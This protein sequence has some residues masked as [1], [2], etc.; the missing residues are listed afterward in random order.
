MAVEGFDA[1]LPIETAGFVPQVGLSEAPDAAGPTLDAALAQA[2]RPGGGGNPAG[3]NGID[4]DARR[5]A[6][7]PDL[8]VEDPAGPYRPPAQVAHVNPLAEMFAGNAPADDPLILHKL[9]IDDMTRASAGRYGDSTEDY[10]WWE[11]TTGDFEWAKRCFMMDVYA[12]VNNAIRGATSQAQADQLARD[13]LHLVGLESVVHVNNPEGEEIVV[14]ARIFNLL[15]ANIDCPLLTLDPAAF[16]NLQL[17]SVGPDLDRGNFEIHVDPDVQ[18]TEDN[19]TAL[20]RLMHIIELVQTYLAS[21]PDNGV[22]MTPKGPITVAELRANYAMTDFRITA[23]GTSYAA[24]GI[25]GYPGAGSATYNNGNP[26]FETSIDHLRDFMITEMRALHFILHEL[27]HV[28]SV[29]YQDFL[30]L[31]LYG[32]PSATDFVASEVFANDISHTIAQA[33]AIPIIR[34]ST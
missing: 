1:A 7:A 20:S 22:F 30:N 14:T 16:A 21:L 23:E 13:Y 19:V 33:R 4:H 5:E 9:T 2:E 28:T 8:W 11:L 18:M 3:A 32:P 24:N 34:Y 15:N 26:I 27:G 29:G 10:S 25:Q 17:S 6:A 31:W 12:G